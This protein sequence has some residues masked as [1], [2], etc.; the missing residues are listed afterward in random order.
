MPRLILVSV[1]ALGTLSAC[2]RH[3]VVPE[4]VMQRSGITTVPLAGM[5]VRY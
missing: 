2:A 5:N 1:L 3:S 4:A